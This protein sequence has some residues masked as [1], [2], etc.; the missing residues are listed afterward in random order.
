MVPSQQAGYP[1][2]DCVLPATSEDQDTSSEN[3]DSTTSKNRDSTTSEGRDSTTS[4]DRDSTS[5][6]DRNPTTSEKGDST[7]S[8]KVDSTTSAKGD[9]TTAEDRGSA[10]YIVRD[11]TN[12]TERDA[13][14][15]QGTERQD[16]QP[17]TYQLQQ[18]NTPS[19]LESQH[20]INDQVSSSTRFDHQQREPFLS[21]QSSDSQQ[22][23]LY[24]LQGQIRQQGYQPSQVLP[25]YQQKFP[26][27]EGTS[28]L[29]PSQQYLQQPYFPSVRL[30]QT[31]CPQHSHRQAQDSVIPHTSHPYSRDSYSKQL[32][33]HG[34]HRNFP[35]GTSS[36]LTG[37]HAA[38]FYRTYEG[39]FHVTQEVLNQT[40][41]QSQQVLPLISQDQPVSSAPLHHQASVR[42]EQ[43]QITRPSLSQIQSQPPQHSQQE[44]QFIQPLMRFPHC[45]HHS[46]NKYIFKQKTQSQT[47]CF[48]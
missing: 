40:S 14:L 15:F 7:T 38:Q 30:T 46:D 28:T 2:S 5:S 35:A 36:A 9:S 3:R 13:I 10:T 31:P 33:E 16:F 20:D 21:D 39:P 42:E 26:Q 12:S 41:Y 6:E 34:F 27:Q 47:F 8:E 29:I 18:Y 4:E 11:S 22:K 17:D 25:N 24:T 44:G 32:Q 1:D 23:M 37:K 43:S 45:M 48:K 19:I